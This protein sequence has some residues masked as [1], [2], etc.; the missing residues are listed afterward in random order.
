MA[1]GAPL[2]SNFTACG[3][4]PRL[5]GFGPAHEDI[6]TALGMRPPPHPIEVSGINPF[7]GWDGGSQLDG[8]H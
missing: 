7:D 3:S 4:H 1:F 8:V 5:V 6:Y 2:M